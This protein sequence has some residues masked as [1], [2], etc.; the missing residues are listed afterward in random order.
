MKVYEHLDGM[1]SIGYG[2]HTLGR[3]DLEGRGLSPQRASRKGGPPAL[4]TEQ[5]SIVGQM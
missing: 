5:S 2:P 4:A 1:L 3:Y